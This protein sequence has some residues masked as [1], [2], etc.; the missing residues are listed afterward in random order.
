MDKKLKEEFLKEGIL[1]FCCYERTWWNFEVIWKLPIEIS[2]IPL[3]LHTNVIN[4][5]KLNLC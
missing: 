1:S 5:E 3:F 2:A 4:V